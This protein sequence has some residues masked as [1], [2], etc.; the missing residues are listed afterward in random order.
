MTVQDASPQKRT[1]QEWMGIGGYL[2]LLGLTALTVGTTLDIYQASP[3]IWFITLA[4]T[5]HLVW[6]GTGAIAVAI[7]W[8]I[9]LIW[10]A[11]LVTATPYGAPVKTGS[12]WA[13]A[14]VGLWLQGILYTS[15][16]GF[17]QFV[18]APLRWRR[19]HTFWLLL[20]LSWGAMGLGAW[21]AP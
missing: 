19:G 3:L 7:V 4:M 5:L 9:S 17:A 20:G 18:L 1:I 11:V 15:L 21:I 8:V 14:L 13:I 12:Q 16:L 2:V 6:N 10:I